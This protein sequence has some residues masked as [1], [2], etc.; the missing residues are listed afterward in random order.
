MKKETRY[1]SS[2][3]STKKKTGKKSKSKWKLLRYSK[4]RK[5]SRKRTKKSEH[6]FFLL[7]LKDQIAICYSLSFSFSLSWFS[8]LFRRTLC[9]LF[10]GERRWVGIFEEGGEYVENADVTTSRIIHKNRKPNTRNRLSCAEKR[11]KKELKKVC[12]A[13]FLWALFSLFLAHTYS[14]F[15]PLFVHSIYLC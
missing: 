3:W 6:S 1:Y 4:K 9:V 12:F 11:K 10:L 15:S 13:Y 14:F 5:S 8:F 7:F 2:F